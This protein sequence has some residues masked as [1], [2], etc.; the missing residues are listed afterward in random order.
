MIQMRDNSGSDHGGSGRGGEKW[1]DAKCTSK[2]E[3]EIERTRKQE[4]PKVLGLKNLKD[5]VTVIEMG[6]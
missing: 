2:V 5:R 4:W 3:V 6:R 1:S